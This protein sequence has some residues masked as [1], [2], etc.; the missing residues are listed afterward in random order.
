MKLFDSHSGYEINIQLVYKHKFVPW[1][2]IYI[3]PVI[4]IK[5]KICDPPNLEKE[6]IHSLK[7]LHYIH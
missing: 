7:S 5:E 6:W 4:N 1:K 2:E 3:K